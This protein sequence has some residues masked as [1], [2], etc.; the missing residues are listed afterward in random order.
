MTSIVPPAPSIPPEAMPKVAGQALAVVAGGKLPAAIAALAQGALFEAVVNKAGGARQIFEAVTAQGAMSL[1]S[2]A[3]GQLP[4]GAKLVMQVMQTQGQFTLR[5]VSVN[6]MAFPPGM[7]GPALQPGL[8]AQAFGIG[9]LLSA[10]TP[11]QGTP[12][13]ATQGAGLPQ[14]GSPLPAGLTATLVRPAETPGSMLAPGTMPQTG[15]LPPDLPPGTQIAVRIAS[16]GP[17]APSPT[18][19]P[20]GFAGTP[21]TSPQGAQPGFAPPPAAGSAASTFAAPP[22]ALP[23]AP[24]GVVPAGSAPQ[25][26]PGTV[27]AHPPGGN[28]LI[29]TDAG[30]LSLPSPNPLPVGSAIVLEVAGRPVLPQAAAKS[31]QPP[32][33]LGK[34]GWPALTEAIETLARTDQ[35][36]AESLLRAIPQANVRLAASLAAFAGALRSGDARVLV[37][38]GVTRGLDK[39]GKRDLASRLKGEVEQLSADAAR[40]AGG[41]EWR[42]M[43]MPFL[44]GAEIDPITLFVRKGKDEIEEDGKG[45]QENRFILE[46]TM[47]RLGRIQFDGL[48]GRESKRFDLIMRTDQPLNAQMRQDIAGIFAEASQLVGTTGYVSFQSG[49]RF[50]ELPPAEPPAGTRITV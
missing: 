29:R 33:G 43:S 25:I 5:I 32:P 2:A 42:A 4:E 46:V 44:H 11:N 24:P 16:I 18:V 12:M 22:T 9:T 3:T 28:A 14:P 17:D 50:V 23:S 15:G 34:E 40:P 10:L 8:G 48:I 30:A 19:L 38:D 31:T 45:G 26:L 20:G 41:G 27:I 36:A 47:S 7:A 13:A 39:A 37:G 21:A 35:Q 1:K 6:G 49:G